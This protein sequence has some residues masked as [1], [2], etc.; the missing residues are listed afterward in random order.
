MQLSM[1]R[2]PSMRPLL[3]MLLLALLIVA[4][5]ASVIFV[6]SQPPPLPPPFGLARNGAIVYG[7]N[8]DLFIADRLDGTVRVL[9]GGSEA[10]FAPV[11]SNQGDRI[12]FAR[13]TD[14]GFQVLSVRPNGAGVTKLA[15][16]P[17]ELDRMAWSPDGDT[18][19]VSY[20][21]TGPHGFTLAVIDS[22]GSGHRTFD[23]DRAADYVSWR[24][25][26]RHIL[27]RG[28]LDD[29]TAGAFIA[30]ADGTNVRQLPIESV[31]PV[32]FEGLGWSPDGKHI[33]F[34]SDG[35]PQG[36]L[37]WRMSI[38]DIDENGALTDLRPLKLD[39]KSTHERLPVWSPDSSQLAFLYQKG[40]TRQ[41]GIFD[42]DGS[43]FRLVGPEAMEPNILGYTWAPDGKTL[44]ITKFPDDES[45]REAERKMWS[46]DLATGAQ[47]EVQTPV[48][49]WQRLAP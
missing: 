25:N 3:A 47:T 40:I 30:D 4:L 26:G 20:S 44:L 9:L 5:V 37:G 28:Q 11:F 32:D 33:S 45:R 8:D 49:T 27:F 36:V 17:G 22:D 34:M 18:L 31:Q 1:A 38:G 35:S 14:E 13:D 16:L 29:G 10:D 7:E 46:I 24:P 48:G 23:V 2:T 19:V 39:P 21:G 42:A 41:V 15:D 6:G 12:A 43:G